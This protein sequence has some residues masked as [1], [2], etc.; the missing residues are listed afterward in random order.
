MDNSQKNTPNL[1]GSDYEEENWRGQNAPKRPK[2]TKRNYLQPDTIILSCNLHSKTKSLLVGLLVNG[3][4]SRL[5]YSKFGE[6]QN[7]VPFTCAFDSLSQ[8][9]LCAYADS[10]EYKAFIDSLAEVRGSN[11][12]Y[13]KV[14]K[15]AGRDGITVQTYKGR[16]EI[17]VTMDGLLHRDIPRFLHKCECSVYNSF[18]DR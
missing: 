9:L 18:F 7:T 8:L 13:F 2:K 15:N 11:N 12:L 1:E 3:C 16:S 10:I 4:K 14:L 5:K 17:L 6:P